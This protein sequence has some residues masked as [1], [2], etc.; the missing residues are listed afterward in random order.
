VTKAFKFVVGSAARK[1]RG[2]PKKARIVDEK[3]QEEPVSPGPSKGSVTDDE[4]G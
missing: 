4:R 1:N 2:R 3:E